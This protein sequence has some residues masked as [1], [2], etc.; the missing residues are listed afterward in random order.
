M[1]TLP[2]SESSALKTAMP[3]TGRATVAGVCVTIMRSC[4][5][6]LMSNGAAIST[7]SNT[8]RRRDIARAAS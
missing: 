3:G 1:V 5:T 7:S 6:P 8:I 2:R 4:Q